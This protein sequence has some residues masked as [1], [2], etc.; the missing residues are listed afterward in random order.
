MKKMEKYFTMIKSSEKEKCLATLITIDRVVGRYLQAII[1]GNQN[2][3]WQTLINFYYN[4]QMLPWV[5]LK[6]M[7]WE[8]YW[9]DT[10]PH[11]FLL[12]LSNVRQG[13]YEGLQ[14]FLQR[15]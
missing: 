13:R 6:H 3:P 14:D 4:Y 8:Y 7:L 15:I 9:V 10:N 2:I 1:R 11:K 5:Q 12:Q